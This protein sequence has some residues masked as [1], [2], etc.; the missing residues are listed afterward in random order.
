MPVVERI[1]PAALEDTATAAAIEDIL[2]VVRASADAMEAGERASQLAAGTVGHGVIRLHERSTPPEPAAA[3]PEPSAVVAASADPVGHGTIRLHGPVGADLPEPAPRPS[4]VNRAPA[5]GGSF[6]HG[7]IRLHRRDEASPSEPAAA[8]AEVPT[9]SVDAA[10][11]ARE[12]I[13]AA[14][15][16]P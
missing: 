3:G 14:L 2:A 13:R 6:G 16:L 15:F 9:G 12:A 7:T 1:R 4:A 8:A 11:A 5:P 10:A